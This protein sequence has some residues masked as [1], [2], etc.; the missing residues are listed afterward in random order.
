M[1]SYTQWVTP[2]YSGWW[3]TLIPN[4]ANLWV[5]LILE[6]RLT[7][8]G[9]P[10]TY[11][12]IHGL[13]LWSMT[14]C[15][16]NLQ[17][18]TWSYAHKASTWL[19]SFNVD[20]FNMNTLSPVHNFKYRLEGFHHNKKLMVCISFHNNTNLGSSIVGVKVLA[21]HKTLGTHQ[22]SKYSPLLCSQWTKYALYTL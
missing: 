21:W 20:L 9:C 3:L 12:H 10:R 19:N 13:R 2:D 18:S 7:R 16:E 4:V 1:W 5:E 14:V 17:V 11:K 8:G 6:N 15:Y 22:G